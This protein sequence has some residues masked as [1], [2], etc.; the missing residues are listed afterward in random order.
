MKVKY[1]RVS[2]TSQSGERFDLDRTQYNLTLLDVVSGGVRMEER[3]EGKKL[4]Q[5]TQTKIFILR[6]SMSKKKKLKKKRVLK[7]LVVRLVRPQYPREFK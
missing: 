1:N 4:L 3:R 2:T 7:K 6:M 5:L